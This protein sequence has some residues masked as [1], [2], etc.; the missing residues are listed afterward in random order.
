MMIS[1]R[2]VE[3]IHFRSQNVAEIALQEMFFFKSRG[4][5][6]SGLKQRYKF[7]YNLIKLCPIA[8]YISKTHPLKDALQIW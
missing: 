3:R 2:D 8:I 7:D 1:G 5:P 4:S 6:R